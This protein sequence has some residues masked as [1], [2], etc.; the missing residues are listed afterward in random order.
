MQR[1]LFILA[2]RVSFY[3]AQYSQPLAL[4]RIALRLLFNFD[5]PPVFLDDTRVAFGAQHAVQ[6]FRFRVGGAHHPQ[7]F[8]LSR[9]GSLSK[10]MS[11]FRYSRIAKALKIH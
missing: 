9:P 4:L 5:T 6:G 8:F 11:H 1:S 3:H 10:T 2:H 7:P